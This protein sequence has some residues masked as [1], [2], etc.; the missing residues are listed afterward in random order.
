LADQVSFPPRTSTEGPSAI[1]LDQVG[2]QI[3]I[4][5]FHC[6]LASTYPPTPGP[7]RRRR[8]STP[9]LLLS[10]RGDREHLARAV[11]ISRSLSVAAGFLFLLL[12]ASEKWRPARTAI[13]VFAPVAM[14]SACD[15]VSGGAPLPSRAAPRVHSTVVTVCARPVHEYS[16]STPHGRTTPT[17]HASYLAPRTNASFF[18]RRFT[19]FF[20][21]GDTQTVAGQCSAACERVTGAAGDVVGGDG[22]RGH[23]PPSAGH[24][25]ATFRRCAARCGLRTVVDPLHQVRPSLLSAPSRARCSR[26][27]KGGVPANRVEA[28]GQRTP[29]L[30]FQQGQP[31]RGKPKHEVHESLRDQLRAVG[32][33]STRRHPSRRESSHKHAIC[34]RTRPFAFVF[35][36]GG[37]PSNA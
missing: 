28:P 5:I 25:R 30:A 19:V 33:A 29:A 10:S 11:E 21:S 26:N 23:G 20:S 9:Y 36:S 14:S 3:T 37:G 1:D 4:G 8:G 2:A 13:Q 31:G 32:A 16:P 34:P 12:C 22:R 24:E 7:R 18:G 27:I 15:S 6:R 35:S 17:S